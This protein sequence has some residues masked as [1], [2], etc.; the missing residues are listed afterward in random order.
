MDLATVSDNTLTPGQSF[1]LRVTVRNRGERRSAATTLRYY[2]SNDAAI[3]TSDTLVGTDPVSALAAAGAGE[4]SIRL[5]APSSAGTYYYGACVDP[6][7]GERLD[8]EQLFVRHS[9]DG[10]RREHP[11][12]VK[13]LLD[14]R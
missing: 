1:D 9:G 13:D 12:H 4:E 7:S 5:T 11:E 6:V 3:S 8:P 10:Q 2:Q 14:E